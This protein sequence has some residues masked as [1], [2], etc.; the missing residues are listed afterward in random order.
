MTDDRAV[1]EQM[2][3][4]GH[5]T[6]VEV[7]ET[8]PDDEKIA[9]PFDPDSIDVVTRTMTVD[10]LLGRTASNMIDLQP[11]FQRRWGVWDVRRQ[12]RLIESLL[13]RIPLPV[14]YA[15]E[16][17]DV[18]FRLYNFF[19]ERLDQEKLLKIYE[20]FEKPLVNLLAQMEIEGIKIDIASNAGISSDLSGAVNL[21]ALLHLDN[22]YF[23]ENI[24]NTLLIFHFVLIQYNESYHYSYL[25]VKT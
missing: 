22:C 9:E 2:D 21:R 25:F 7:E 13:L 1:S 15:A 18:T 24:L 5:T 23:L 19:K 16:D 11:D 17:A 20:L 4:L 6:G 8:S 12:S 14:L 10:L 3:T